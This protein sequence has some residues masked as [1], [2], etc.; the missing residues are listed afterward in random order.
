MAGSIIYLLLTNLQSQADFRIQEKYGV[1]YINPLMTF[2]LDIQDHRYE[3]N[4]YLK[5]NQSELQQIN[6]LNA[7]I[8]K[9]IEA[10]DKV[11][12]NLNK[13]LLVNKKWSNIKDKW[14]DLSKSSLKLNSS[15][16]YEKHT[17]LIS[18]TLTLIGNITVSSNLILDPDFDTYYLM[19][20]YS[21]ISPMIIDK[22]YTA[23]I[24]GTN[25]IKS[26]NYNK[27]D[28]IKMLTIIDELNEK[29][30]GNARIVYNYNNS[31]KS[32]I[33]NDVNAS[34]KANKAFLN[35]MNGLIDGTRKVSLSE[36]IL[37]ANKAINN[38]KKAYYTYSNNLYKLLG[39][40]VKR[41][42]DQ[43]PLTIFFTLLVL[44][45]IG[46]LF[47]GFYLSLIN[48]LKTLET[49]SLQ[50]T[51]GDLTAKVNIDTK[52][53]IADLAKIFNK[54]AESLKNNEVF[55]KH[56]QQSLLELS[57]PVIKLGK[58]ILFLPI[59]GILDSTRAIQL[60]ESLLE[61]I[62]QTGSTVAI[63]DITA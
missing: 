21:V 54:M 22:I 19:D 32:K 31:M 29:L 27:T 63:I 51:N 15:K 20:S 5:G 11:D 8:D 3:T 56:Q 50:I 16:S 38:N 62:A 35:L 6:E 33:D 60:T 14:N 42:T 53:E 43:E 7:N 36:Y 41:Y 59:V 52:D 25:V 34:Y 45:A 39:E 12:N 58:G 30:K 10:V 4:L 49:S 55:I 61:K 40:R 28:F 48:S 2:F 37:T 13:I 24:E 44:L 47:A 57:T 46:Y 18:D 17:E 1:E 23:M 26:G 9:D